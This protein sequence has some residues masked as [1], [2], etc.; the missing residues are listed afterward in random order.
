MELI[1]RKP[2]ISKILDDA[3]AELCKCKD[4]KSS[5][6]FMQAVV[7]YSQYLMQAPV[8]DA[9]RVTRCK[10]CRYNVSAYYKSK[11]RCDKGQHGFAPDFFCG[12]GQPR[13][14]K[15]ETSKEKERVE[16]HGEKGKNQ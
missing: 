3:H 9:V 2:L 13:K 6:L 15:V 11:R 1:D 4:K 12:Y 16:Q 5:E 14:A 7:A 8:V 10:D